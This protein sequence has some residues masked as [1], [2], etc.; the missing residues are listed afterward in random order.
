MVYDNI[1]DNIIQIGISIA[2]GTALDYDIILKKHVST[3]KEI[4]IQ[5]D[6]APAF[7]VLVDDITFIPT[8]NALT[9]G[10]IADI[11]V[12]TYIWNPANPPNLNV[13]QVGRIL[14]INSDG[15]TV[16]IDTILYLRILFEG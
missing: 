8:T 3:I 7:T 9:T 6:V 16:G 1:G 2:A 4:S 5:F 13:Q 11:N 14:N 15:G 12:H 10:A